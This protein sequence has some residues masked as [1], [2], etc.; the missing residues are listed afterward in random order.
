LLAKACGKTKGDPC[1]RFFVAP[2]QDFFLNVSLNRVFLPGS[3]ACFAQQYLEV[4]CYL[5]MM[6]KGSLILVVLISGFMAC[7]NP[8]PAP[9]PK[10]IA[11]EN[12]GDKEQGKK[13]F[14]AKCAS[15]HM[16]NKDMSGPALKGVEDRWSDKEKLYAFI[17][18][19]EEIIGKD[20]YARELWLEWNQTQML[21]HPDLTDTDIRAILD[22][23]NQVSR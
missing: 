4:P 21:P 15:C 3:P 19:S 5:Y 12:L 7:S 10:S 6:L 13:L 16:V 17:R 8:E 18:N 22:Y 1:G 2:T 11:V 9:E 20:K 23:I 14:Y